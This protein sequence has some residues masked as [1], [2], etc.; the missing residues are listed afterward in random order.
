MHATTTTSH[1]RPQHRL[2]GQIQHRGP[3]GAHDV[4]SITDLVNHAINQPNTQQCDP[5][6][7]RDPNTDGCQ[8]AFACHQDSSNTNAQMAKT[9]TDIVA[10]QSGF[11]TFGTRPVTPHCTSW[12]ASPQ[13]SYLHRLKPQQRDGHEHPAVSDH[14]CVEPANAPISRRQ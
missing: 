7:S 2:H 10:K 8:I 9:L 3:S 12:L 13:G 4:S 14:Q 11:A 6:T 1:C 5:G